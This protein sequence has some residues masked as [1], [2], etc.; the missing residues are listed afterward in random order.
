M[1]VDAG[2]A[3]AETPDAGP[4]KVTKPPVKK[5]KRPKKRPRKR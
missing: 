2:V 4:K 5:K 1:P 3:A